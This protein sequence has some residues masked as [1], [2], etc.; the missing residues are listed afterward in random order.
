[1]GGSKLWDFRVFKCRLTGG[2]GQTTAVRLEIGVVR[3]RGLVG[4]AVWRRS[5]TY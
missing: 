3:G 1:M 2:H 4:E 5:I